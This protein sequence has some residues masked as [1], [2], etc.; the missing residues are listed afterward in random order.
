MIE[1][2]GR[3]LITIE[4]LCSTALGILTSVLADTIGDALFRLLAVAVTDSSCWCVNSKSRGHLF[5]SQ[6]QSGRQN[7][8]VGS[9]ELDW[10]ARKRVASKWGTR[11]GNTKA[12]R[13]CIGN[14]DG[15]ESR[16]RRQ[17]SR[18]K[19]ITV[20][21]EHNKRQPVYVKST[22]T[23]LVTRLTRMEKKNTYE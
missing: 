16:S 14:G 7:N 4:S 2:Q 6:L 18:S 11:Q 15:D 23:N 17:I 5:S 1:S 22:S 13:I 8:E 12:K 10:G 21:R 19:A 9:W 20:K 3:N